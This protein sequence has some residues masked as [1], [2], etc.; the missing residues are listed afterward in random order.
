MGRDLEAA[1]HGRLRR[2]TNRV[3]EASRRLLADAAAHQLDRRAGQHSAS[4]ASLRDER[5]DHDEQGASNGRQVWNL[6]EEQEA[7]QYTPH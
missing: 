6:G 3:E 1:R 4:S 7:E 5:A 2:L